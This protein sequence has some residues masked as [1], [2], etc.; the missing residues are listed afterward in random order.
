MNRCLDV[1]DW[2]EWQY[3]PIHV[4]SKFQVGRKGK[5]R[6][7]GSAKSF[8][9]LVQL[10][11]SNVFAFLSDPHDFSFIDISDFLTV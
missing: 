10:P 6:C 2:I 5:D 7:Y 9:S 8:Y 11:D 3:N 1:K 4:F